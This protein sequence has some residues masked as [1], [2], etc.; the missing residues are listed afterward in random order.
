MRMRWLLLA[1]LALPML[2]GALAP[3]EAGA[4]F[5]GQ[6]G[7]IAF[8]R[9]GENVSEPRCVYTA[10]ANGTAEVAL[11]PPCD[12]ENESKPRWSPSGTQIAYEGYGGQLD[13]VNARTTATCVSSSS[14]P[15]LG[16]RASDGLPTAA[17]SWSACSTAM[18]KGS[19]NRGS[20]G[21]NSTTGAYTTILTTPFDTCPTPTGRPT[22]S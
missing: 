5:P 16:P 19:A 18:A 9:G 13:L 20:S 7:K 12:A 15:E 4:T 1:A 8:S 21:L 10:N 11:L 22:A 2:V 3:A 17:R 14:T 6:N